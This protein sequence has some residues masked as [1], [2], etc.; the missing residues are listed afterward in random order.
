MARRLLLMMAGGAVLVAVMACA[1]GGAAAGVLQHTAKIRALRL[2]R[3]GE[4]GEWGRLNALFLTAVLVSGYLL[5]WSTLSISIDKVDMGVLSMARLLPPTYWAGFALLLASTIIW[6]FGG[7]T[8]VFHFLL[9]ALWMGYLFLG[10]E[11]MEAH[12]RGVSS[13]SQAWG[14]AYILEDREREYSYFPWLGFHYAFAA[15]AE[16]TNV[17][18]LAMIKMGSWVMYLALAA[19]LIAF[20]GRVLPDKKSILVAT[21]AAL[22]MVAVMGVGFTPHQMVF[23]LTLFAYFFLVSPGA[24]PVANRLLLISL[25]FVILITHG[26]TALVV[27]YVA[28]LAALARW[29]RLGVGP[30]SASTAS[31]SLL[32]AVLFAAWLLY[33]S[34][35]WFPRA[36]EAFRDNVLRDPIAFTSSFGHVSPAGAGRAEVSLLSFAFLAVL[37]VWLLSVVVRRGFWNGLRRDRLFPLLVVSGMPILIMGTG[38]FSYEGFFRVFF[39]AVPFLAWFL[40]RESVARRSTA[41]FLLLLLGLGFVLLYAREFEELPTSQHLEGANFLVDA[42]GPD[43]RVIQGDCLSLGAITHTI[44]TPGM[45]CAYPNPEDPQLEQVPNARE[46]T[47]AV[48]SEFGERSAG[49]AFAFGEPWWECLKNS[50]RR[51]GF[52]KVYSNGGYDI[53]ARPAVLRPEDPG[54]DLCGRGGG[55]AGSVR[56]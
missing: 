11:L 50:V 37:L 45:G 46:F 44:D 38:N 14:V 56:Q 29:K 49:F 19:G 36:V 34:D 23:G 20:F 25:Y 52:A 12:P 33:S 26:L 24:A 6:Y 27:I 16:L 1:R 4:T 47:F 10:P 48:L 35:F 54:A 22:A 39:Y 7:E 2:P 32:F 53:F 21:L 31:L 17:S 5:V 30:W 40:A 41:A 15:L 9:V 18:H 51:E 8:K 55:Q 43:S 28:A 13:Y 3:L 42:A